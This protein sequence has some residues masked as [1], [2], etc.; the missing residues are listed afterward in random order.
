[1]IGSIISIIYFPV[2]HIVFCMNQLGGVGATRSQFGTATS[3]AKP[4]GVQRKSECGK[5]FTM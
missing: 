3:A 2:P 5:K 1:M 4:D